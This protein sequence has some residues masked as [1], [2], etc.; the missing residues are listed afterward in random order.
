[1]ADLLFAAA[2]LLL[3][4]AAAGLAS[5]W[6]AGNDLD[7]MLAVQLL[8]AAGIAVLLLLTP[9][10]G[11]SSLLDTALLLALLAALAACAYRAAFGPTRPKAG[12]PPAAPRP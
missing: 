5:L 12:R 11:D 3:L 9:A 4:L 7:R 8:G 1:M 10:M 2:T 6:W